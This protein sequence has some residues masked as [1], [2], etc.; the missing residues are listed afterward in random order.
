VS[1]V[2]ER[3]AEELVV[4]VERAGGGPGDAAA[5]DLG[6]DPYG[7]P[8]VQDVALLADGLATDGVA[9]GPAVHHDDGQA[10]TGQQE[11]RGLADRPAADDDDSWRGGGRC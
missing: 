2:D 4:A 10:P 1:A 5:S 8:D 6:P 11:C 9:A 3:G 7:V